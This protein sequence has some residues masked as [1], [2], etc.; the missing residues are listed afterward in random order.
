MIKRSVNQEDIIIFNVP[1]VLHKF[2]ITVGKFNI[3]LLIIHRTS[4]QKVNKVVKD[5][6]NIINQHNLTNIHRT[7]HS[8]KIETIG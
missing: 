7:L 8:T 3:R 4:I 2:T 6:N 5:L 1:A